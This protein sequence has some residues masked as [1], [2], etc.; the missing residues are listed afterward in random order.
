[1]IISH[2]H[3][4][5]FLHCR[6][7]AGSSIT[8]YLQP[9]LG[10]KDIVVGPYADLIAHNCHFNQKFYLD[11]F[12][13]KGIS[14]LTKSYLRKMLGRQK[15]TKKNLCDVHRELYQNITRVNPEHIL[16]KDL[17]NHYS[18]EW[19]EYYK[20][21]FVRNPYDRAVSDYKWRL[22]KSPNKDISFQEFLERVKDQ[23]LPD[24]EHIVPKPAD[25][26]SIYTIDNKPAVDFIGKYEN[27]ERDFSDICK[28]IGIPYK[29]NFF[30]TS[31][32]QRRDNDLRSEYTPKTK[33][34]VEEIFAKEIH[35]FNYE[36]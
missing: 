9:Y 10:Q 33:A 27:L 21:C 8:V 18:E 3:K 36:L 25:N 28:K 34:L 7:V 29:K 6:K 31:K 17:K 14:L 13:T 23:S 19:R 4:F 24:P 12:S 35:Y 30:P 22:S 15:F 32:K 5:I 11:F 26:W 16:A 1:M 2:K 20:F